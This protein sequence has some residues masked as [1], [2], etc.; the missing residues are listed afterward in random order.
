MTPYPSNRRNTG[1]SLLSAQI[2]KGH[3]HDE[4]SRKSFRDHRA[5]I[6]AQDAE[7]PRHGAKRN[8]YGPENLLRG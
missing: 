3:S 4:H 2:E 7:R 8:L 6:P 5:S 1:M